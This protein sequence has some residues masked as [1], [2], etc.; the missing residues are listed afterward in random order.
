MEG[1]RR[2]RWP[3]SSHLAVDATYVG[4]CG[5]LRRWLYGMRPAASAR[6]HD[7]SCR[8]EELA[9]TTGNAPRRCCTGPTGTSVCRAR[10]VLTFLGWHKDLDDTVAFFKKNYELKVWGQR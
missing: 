4:I 2:T 8:W 9:M 6:E 3:S 7:Y 1:S 10:D 5:K